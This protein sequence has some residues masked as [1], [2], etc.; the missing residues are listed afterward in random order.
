MTTETKSLIIVCCHG[1][2]LGGPSLGADESEW[3]LA[4]FQKGEAPTCIEHLKAGLRLLIDKANSLLI[5]SGYV[6]I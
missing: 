3:L 5:L 4:P 2:W 1:I 6:H